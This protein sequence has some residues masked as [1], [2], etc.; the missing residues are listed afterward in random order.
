MVN[1]LK[2]EWDENVIRF[3][4]LLISGDGPAAV[5]D[6]QWLLRQALG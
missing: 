5:N 4:A 6:L 3:G 2:E 1:P